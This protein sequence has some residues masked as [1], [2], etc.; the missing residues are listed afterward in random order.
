[1]AHYPPLPSSLY[2]PL[3]INLVFISHYFVNSFDVWPWEMPTSRNICDDAVSTGDGTLLFLQDFSWLA[4][5]PYY[6]GIFFHYDYLIS[7]FE[8]SIDKTSC[9]TFV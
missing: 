5:N 3:D 7:S 6:E 8:T 2:M 9:F 1:M 4:N